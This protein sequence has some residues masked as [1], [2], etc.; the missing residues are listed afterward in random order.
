VLSIVV[1]DIPFFSAKI[2]KSLS[3]ISKLG[4][5]AYD[6]SIDIKEIIIKNILINVIL[7]LLVDMSISI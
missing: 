7:A 4:E 3:H 5:L 6:D 2:L 1:F